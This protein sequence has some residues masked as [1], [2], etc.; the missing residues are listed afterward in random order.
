MVRYIKCMTCV[1]TLSITVFWLPRPGSGSEWQTVIGGEEPV[2]TDQSNHANQTQTS[3]NPSPPLSLGIEERFPST[4]TPSFEGFLTSTDPEELKIDYW[5]LKKTVNNPDLFILFETPDSIL[6]F[7]EYVGINIDD[8]AFKPLRF[9]ADNFFP[10]TVVSLSQLKKISET[11]S[12]TTSDGSLKDYFKRF[13][14]IIFKW[15]QHSNATKKIIREDLLPA[16]K[17]RIR[18]LE[19]EQNEQ[20]TPEKVDPAD[21]CPTYNPSPQGP[22]TIWFYQKG[23]KKN[24]RKCSYWPDGHIH[25][26]IPFNNKKRHGVALTHG[27]TKKFD[28]HYIVVITPY[29]NDKLH[30]KRYQYALNEKGKRYIQ[31][32]QS[33]VK[34]ARHG[35]HI[36]YYDNKQIKKIIKY[37]KDTKTKQTKYNRKGEMTSCYKW[38]SEGGNSKDCMPKK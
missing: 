27:F 33:Y 9:A 35:D 8:D 6:K 23:N 21:R 34:G 4:P 1:I 20:D 14:H 24:Y 10:C 30:G 11:V 25:H 29:S 19:K 26:D 32:K 13:T 28:F 17:K 22:T 7:L 37:V 36:E 18:E 16:M 3:Q 12:Q 5:L 38:D 15:L 31:F 2:V